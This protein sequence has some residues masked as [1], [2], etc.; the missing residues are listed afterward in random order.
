VFE[1]ASPPTQ[2]AGLLKAIYRFTASRGLPSL[3]CCQVGARRVV[4]RA[5]AA[6]RSKA[7]AAPRRLTC[8]FSSMLCTWFFTVGRLIFSCLANFL[9]REP[10][11]Y[12][13]PSAAE[14]GRA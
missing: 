3:S 1:P 6:S 4:A 14:L 2:R 12:E 7:A 8:S 5:R 9:V 11:I 10:P 13:S